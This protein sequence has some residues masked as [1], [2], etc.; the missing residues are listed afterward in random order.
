MTNIKEPTDLIEKIILNSTSGSQ[1][2]GTTTPDSDVDYR[3]IFLPSKKYLYGLSRLIEESEKGTIIDKDKN[4][5]N[6]KHAIDVKYFELKKFINLASKCNPNILEMVFLNNESI[7]ESSE[8]Y[9]TIRN[10]SDKFLSKIFIYE[11]F[12]EYAKAQRYKMIIKLDNYKLYKKFVNRYNE[13]ILENE[14]YKNELISILIER[15]L[16]DDMNIQS[17]NIEFADTHFLRSHSLYACYKQIN[18]RLSK[19]SNREELVLKY[20]YDTKFASHY[21]RLLFEGIELLETGKLEFPL[22]DANTIV[23]IKLGNYSLNEIL[24]MGENMEN[25]FRISFERSKVNDYSDFDFL[26]NMTIKMFEDNYT[27]KGEKL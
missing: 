26:N 27:K 1:L 6:T 21:I 4:N 3:G 17:S 22:K 16:I 13:L 12:R 5:K 20:G 9:E 8:E 15:K 19:V 24:E 7:I 2:Y 14:S 23:E 10:N 18:E 25:E 11:R